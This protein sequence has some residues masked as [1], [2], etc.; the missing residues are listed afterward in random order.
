MLNKRLIIYLDQ[1]AIEL[2]YI[3]NI[4]CKAKFLDNLLLKLC[5]FFEIFIAYNI[6]IS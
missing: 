5:F 6:S 4:V 3:D 2:A 1:F